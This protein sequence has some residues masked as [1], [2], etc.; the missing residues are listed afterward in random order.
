MLFFGKTNEFLR[1]T[2]GHSEDLFTSFLQN[3]QRMVKELIICTNSYKFIL[4]TGL[5][6]P[7]LLYDKMFKPKIIYNWHSHLV[8]KFVWWSLVRSVFFLVS[9]WNVFIY[10]YLIYCVLD[11]ILY[12]FKYNQ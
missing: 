11:F 6:F 8:L 3:I 12:I 1:C 4:P 9:A 5:L 7:V 10:M 2:F